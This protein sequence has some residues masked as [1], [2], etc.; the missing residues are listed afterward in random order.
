[1]T[2]VII[3]ILIGL[4]LLL[5]EF[6]L[7]P[8]ITVAGIGGVILVAGGVTWAYT[9]FGT[10]AGHLTLLGTALASVGIV[11]LALRSKTWKYFM[12]NTNIEG[13]VDGKIDETQIKTGD[14]GVAI[15]RLAPMGKIRING[16]LVEAKSTGDF[17]DQKKE[18][19]VTKIEGSKVIVKLKDNT[20]E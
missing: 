1:M 7:I 6:L 9:G 12:L 3:V 10:T 4:F 20:N 17:I 5:V 16:I 8:G 19:I 15:S 2:G 14:T 11:I 18:V 13:S